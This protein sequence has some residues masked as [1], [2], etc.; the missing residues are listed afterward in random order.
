MFPQQDIVGPET[1][2]GIPANIPHAIE[3]M[4]GLC[5]YL[6]AT[7][8]LHK[9]IMLAVRTLAPCVMPP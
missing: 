5:R 8:S 2:L 3:C 9:T 6:L 1:P 7:A 4:M